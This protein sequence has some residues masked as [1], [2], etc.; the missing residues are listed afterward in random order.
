MKDC[1]SVPVLTNEFQIQ[2]GDTSPLPHYIHLINDGNHISFSK[3][4]LL[5]PILSEH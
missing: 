3:F 5:R 4:A 2:Y 1:V